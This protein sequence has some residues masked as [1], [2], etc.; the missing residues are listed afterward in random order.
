M[1]LSA[2]EKREKDKYICIDPNRQTRKNIYHISE[3]LEKKK[4]TRKNKVT[5][6]G[7]R[8]R[9]TG[10]GVGHIGRPSHH[11]MPPPGHELT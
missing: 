4:E 5:D 9:L 10:P 7:T 2:L 3:P 8:I 1:H 6:N 11:F